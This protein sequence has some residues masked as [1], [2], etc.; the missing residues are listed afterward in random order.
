MTK[1]VIF[2]IYGF[3]KYFIKA[4]YYYLCVCKPV[5][6][7]KYL[8]PKNCRFSWC[9]RFYVQVMKMAGGDDVIDRVSRKKTG[10]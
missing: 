7:T 5:S 8:F 10:R 1:V 9:G 2:F 4:K 3:N 6:C